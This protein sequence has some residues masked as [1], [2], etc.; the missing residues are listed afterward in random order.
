MS[1]CVR[2]KYLILIFLGDL[3]DLGDFSDITWQSPKFNCRKEV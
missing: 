2:K 1:L 3:G